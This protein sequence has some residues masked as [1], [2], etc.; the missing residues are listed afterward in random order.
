MFGLLYE[1]RE[2]L[3][4]PFSFGHV[5]HIVLKQLSSLLGHAIRSPHY[6]AEV[7]E[8][9][10]LLVFIPHFSRKMKPRRPGYLYLVEQEPGS[11]I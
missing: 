4:L 7:F 9:D 11:F 2:Y 3:K 5:V 10:E 8:L 1:L 6:A